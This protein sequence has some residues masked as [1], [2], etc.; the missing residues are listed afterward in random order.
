MTP[1]AS[2]PAVGRGRPRSVEADNAI[3]DATI[4][5]LA[6][7]GWAGLT[8]N[9]VAHHAGVSTATL[10]RRYSSKEDLVCAAVTARSE[11]L[12]TIDTGSLEGDLRAKLHDIVDRMRGPG[13]RVMEGVIGEAVRNPRLAQILRNT[14]FAAGRDDFKRVIDRAVERGEIERPADTNLVVNFV[15]GPLFHRLLITGEPV[16]PRVADALLPL[17]LAAL[18]ATR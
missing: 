12:S 7:E 1:V 17:V 5:L 3:A 10:Y 11:N 2:T 16:T 6:Q 14:A 8:M 9:G 15:V 4:A 18:G 13:G